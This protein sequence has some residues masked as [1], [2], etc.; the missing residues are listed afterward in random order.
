[1]DCG[2]QPVIEQPNIKLRGPVTIGFRSLSGESQTAEININGATTL[3]ASKLIT[4][5]AIQQ[6][7]SKVCG[8]QQIAAADEIKTDTIY[9]AA[10]RISKDFT[11]IDNL[12]FE[13]IESINKSITNGPV[14]VVAIHKDGTGYLLA[15]LEAH[16]TTSRYRK[17][18][19]PNGCNCKQTIHGSFKISQQENIV[20]GS[21][22]LIIENEEAI[23][24]LAMGIYKQY[25]TNELNEA[26][27]FISEGLSALDK[28]KREEDSPN[29]FP[30][31]I[32]GIHAYDIPDVISRN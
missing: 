30:V 3:G 2:Q 31:Q 20:Y 14:E 10:F 9:G 6:A 16:E 32:D 26:K 19:V 7:S 28:E 22:P 8:C 24:S 17:Y 27:F 13:S 5:Q 4:Y 15:R 25:Y 1:M 18:L 29:V 12:C 21:Q 11:Y 23:I